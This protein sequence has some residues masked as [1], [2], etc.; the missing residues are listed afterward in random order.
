MNAAQNRADFAEL[1]RLVGRPL[2]GSHRSFPT[3]WSAENA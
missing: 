3:A 1:D 2:R